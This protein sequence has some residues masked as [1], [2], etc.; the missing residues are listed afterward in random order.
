[1]A[2]KCW[3]K[4]DVSLPW[5]APLSV[6]QLGRSPKGVIGLKTVAVFQTA[7]GA[8]A[9]LSPPF[10]RGKGVRWDIALKGVTVLRTVWG[11]N[12]HCGAINNN[13]SYTMVCS[14]PFTTPHIHQWCQKAGVASG[15]TPLNNNLSC[16]RH[17]CYFRHNKKRRN[18]LPSFFTICCISAW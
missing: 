13:L 14:L 7:T 10:L 3:Y 16:Y 11:Y 9:P 5:R 17:L 18:Y 2:H 12:N 15:G 4:R 8:R 6:G 1:M